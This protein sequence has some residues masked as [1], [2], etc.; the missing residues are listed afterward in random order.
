MTVML[1]L[2]GLGVLWLLFALLSV[3]GHLYHL[4]R[5]TATPCRTCRHEASTALDWEEQENDE[6]DRF[7]TALGR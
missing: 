6:E 2:I 4:V 1:L 7:W 3:V 5:E